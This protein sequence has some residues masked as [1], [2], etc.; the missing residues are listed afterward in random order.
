MEEEKKY[1]RYKLLIEIDEEGR[2]ISATQP[3]GE[4]LN[5]FDE[6]IS[7]DDGNTRLIREASSRCRWVHLPDC[8]M[9]CLPY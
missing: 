6:K 2:I 9:F 8:R 5:L 3:N 7:L 4:P 1:T